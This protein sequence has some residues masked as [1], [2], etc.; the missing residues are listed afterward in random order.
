MHGNFATQPINA[1]N[2]KLGNDSI[3]ILKNDVK[4]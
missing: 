3:S 4:I 1:A 2:F